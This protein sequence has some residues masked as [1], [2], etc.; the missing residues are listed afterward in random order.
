MIWSLQRE[1]KKEQKI[2]DNISKNS[3]NAGSDSEPARERVHAIEQLLK[4][5]S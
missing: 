5:L 4:E 1:F 2:V 3:S